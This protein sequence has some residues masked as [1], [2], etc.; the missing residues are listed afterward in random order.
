MLA[1]NTVVFCLLAEYLQN[2]SENNLFL[3]KFCLLY[4][5]EKQIEIERIQI[6]IFLNKYH[7]TSLK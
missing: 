1:I 6:I 4:F 3:L 5:V 2:H 7:G